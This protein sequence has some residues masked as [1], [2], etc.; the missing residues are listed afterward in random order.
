MRTF[1]VQFDGRVVEIFG[2]GDVARYHVALMGEPQIREPNRKGRRIVEV[3]ASHM[4]VDQD[5]MARLEPLLDKIRDTIRIAK[6]K[7]LTSREPAPH[8]QAQG[9]GGQV[10]QRG[11]RLGSSHPGHSGPD[12]VEVPLCITLTTRSVQARGLAP[13]VE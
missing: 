6:D 13:S 9:T 11:A 4:G 12:T 8:R 7:P 10:Q 2:S 1:V 5:E 3:G